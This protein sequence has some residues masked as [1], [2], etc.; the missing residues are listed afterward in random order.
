MTDGTNLQGLTAGLESGIKTI[1][2]EIKD[3]HEEV[4]RAKQNIANISREQERLS[5]ELGAARTQLSGLDE[6]QEALR[7]ELAKRIDELTRKTAEKAQELIALESHLRTLLSLQKE[8]R[9]E[10][11]LEREKGQFV[12]Q[13]ARLLDGIH[14]GPVRFLFA[15]AALDVCRAHDIASEKFQGVADQK[16]VADALDVLTAAKQ[17]ASDA[18]RAEAERFQNMRAMVREITD[19]RDGYLSR[20]QAD[21]RTQTS[22]VAE[23]QSEAEIVA[24]GSIPE[25]PTH[26]QRR[27]IYR[28]AFA[29]AGFASVI[30]CL[31]SWVFLIPAACAFLVSWLNTDAYRSQQSARHRK[32]LQTLDVQIEQIKAAIVTREHEVK[33]LVSTCGERLARIDIA[34]P[35]LSPGMMPADTLQALIGAA[36]EAETGWRAQHVAS[37]ILSS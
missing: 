9:A 31:Y 30:A 17:S 37:Q 12:L 33:S 23:R 7:A 3:A 5:S 4:E 18:D 20:K 10:R 27:R 8:E 35:Q 15:T 14:D 2:Q 1:Q 29:A 11:H 34:L 6:G 24:R 21:E 22:L 36:K 16:T 32:K 13:S 28:I 19:R 26:Q 25:E